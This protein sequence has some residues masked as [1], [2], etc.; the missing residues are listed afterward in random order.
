MLN[1]RNSDGRTSLYPKYIY[2]LQYPM[3]ISV[4]EFSLNS[5][6]HTPNSQARPMGPIRVHPRNKIR[7]YLRTPQMS[8]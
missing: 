2:Q 8:F 4:Q 6:D 1:K 5:P 3:K 7:Q